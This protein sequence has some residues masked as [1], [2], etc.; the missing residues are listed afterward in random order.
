MS[1][2]ARAEYDRI[3]AELAETSGITITKMFGVP[4]LKAANGKAFAAFYDDA[5]VFKLGE[6]RLRRLWRSPARSSSTRWAAVR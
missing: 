6:Q 3:A 1:V 5:M 4:S 2:D